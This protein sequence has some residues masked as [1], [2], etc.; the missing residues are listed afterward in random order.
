MVGLEPLQER[1]VQM[2]WW[3]IGGWVL[4]IVFAMSLVVVAGRA[5][6]RMEEMRN[7]VPDGGSET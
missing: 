4:G 7:S 6:D 2:I 5:D 1:T 3:I